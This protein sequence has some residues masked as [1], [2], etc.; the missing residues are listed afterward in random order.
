MSAGMQGVELLLQLDH[1]LLVDER[2]HQ[3]VARH[4]LLVHETLHQPLLLQDLDDLLEVLLDALR[5]A[6][7]LDFGHG[8]GSA[9][10][11]PTR[12]SSG[13]AP[14]AVQLKRD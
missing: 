14:A 5:R 8:I 11:R 6:G 10:K 2:L 13:R 4:L 9:R 7:F 1:V 12:D 3:L